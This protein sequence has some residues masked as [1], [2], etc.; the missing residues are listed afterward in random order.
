SIPDFQ[1]FINI[2]QGSAA[3]LRTQIYISREVNIFS[4]LDAKELIQ[5]LKSISKMLQS[6]HSS[7]KKL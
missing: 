7:L 1:R 5:E 6:L 3:E 2:A 4:D